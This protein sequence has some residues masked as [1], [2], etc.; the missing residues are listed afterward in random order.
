MNSTTLLAFLY[1]IPEN[2]QSAA[3][4]KL[5]T[6]LK[7][8]PVNWEAVQDKL[9]AIFREHP[10][11]QEICTRCQTQLETKTSEALLALL[12]SQEVL[13]QYQPASPVARS[14]LPGLPDNKETTEITNTAV[15]ILESEHPAEMAKK[16]LLPLSDI[17]KSPQPVGNK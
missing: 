4:K 3:F 13:N 2:V 11:L 15:A 12:P 6:Q 14:G 8:Q 10:K 7:C 1:A 17:P 16:L 5:A 9:D